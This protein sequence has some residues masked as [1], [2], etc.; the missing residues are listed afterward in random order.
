LPPARILPYYNHLSSIIFTFITPAAA[1]RPWS[2]ADGSARVQAAASRAR[3]MSAYLQVYTR[4]K[5]IG[6]SFITN[7]ILMNEE[8]VATMACK[9][10]VLERL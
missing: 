7:T 8:S 1:L 2:C 3:Y 10:D 6:E 4:F 9:L 5:T